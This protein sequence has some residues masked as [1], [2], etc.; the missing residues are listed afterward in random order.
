MVKSIL[1]AEDEKPIAESLAYC[2]EKEGF[3]TYQ[4]HDGQEALNKYDKIKPTL[5]LLDLMLPKVNGQQVC[6]SIRADSDTPIIML[7]AK[8]S[9]LDKVVGLEIGADDYITKPFSM[10]EL[11]ARINAVLR[12]TA[13]KDQLIDIGPFALNESSHEIKFENKPLDLPLKEF[14][15]LK[16]LLINKEK[17]VSR[18]NLLKIVWGEDFFG[19]EKTLDVHIRRLRQKIEEDSVN[20]KYIK[21]VR[22]VGYKFSLVTGTSKK[23]D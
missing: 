7:T 17:V 10:R 15:I 1:I 21:T 12:R 5:V 19:D 16:T 22:G 20:S 23:L 3:T 13:E 18:K 9:E 2:L 8:D 6:K 11:I 14:D 4:A